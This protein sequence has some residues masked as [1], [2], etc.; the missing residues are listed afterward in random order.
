MIAG[1]QLARFQPVIKC[2][3]EPEIEA[4]PSIGVPE[5][6]MGWTLVG[7]LGDTSLVYTINLG[8]IGDKDSLEKTRE[9]LQRLHTST[10]GKD[11]TFLH[12]DYPGLERLR[13]RLNVLGVSEIDDKDLIRRLENEAKSFSERV[14]IS[15]S[16]IREKVQVLVGRHP[17]PNVLVLAYPKAMDRYCVEG[18]IG[19]RGVPRKTSLEKA[20]E[21]ARKQNLTLD[22]FI[23]IPP[24]QI[25]YEPMVLR[26]VVKAICMDSDIPIQILRPRTLEEYGPS[27][28]L[29]EDDATT[30]WNLV[31]ATFF[32]AN[33]LPWRVRGLMEDA[34]YL[35]VSFFRDRDDPASVKTTL[36]QVFS[37]DSEGFV[38]K[39]E[40][41]VLDQTRSPHVTQAEASRLAKQAI[42]VYRSNK[43]KPP[44]RL[45]IHKTS[46]FDVGEREGFKDG[47]SEVAR[48][49][50]VAFGT[51]D[52][53]LMRWGKH[54]P[55]RGT[56]VKLPD[57]SAL[58]YTFGYIPY[59]GVYP[60]P[61][62][63][64]PLDTGAS[65]RLVARSNL[66]RHS[67][68]DEA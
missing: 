18:G 21:K 29:R 45:V 15:S 4:G 9:L 20:I 12:I 57:K 11:Q 41:A 56:M 33:H 42:E 43:G 17:S 53:K 16:I 68:L 6:K 50:L 66:Q 65:W 3:E 62:V 26:S 46:R 48:I 22:S 25:H 27:Q 8:L 49:D 58:L 10:P 38:F 34:C 63:P 61:R 60:G 1:L 54:P 28:T 37:L 23:G 13:V 64:S 40:K 59:L 7:P 30:F 19:R 44:Q 24:P 35:G 2:L 67:L 32:K 51:R 47:A 36:A 14:E 5:P 31:V 55:I 39:G 52:I